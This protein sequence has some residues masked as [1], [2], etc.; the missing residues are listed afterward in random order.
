MKEEE[1]NKDILHALDQ[2]INPSVMG[3]SDVNRILNNPEEKEL[4]RDIHLL[5][6]ALLRSS[7]LHRPDVEAEWA[8]FN[9]RPTV[10][11]KDVEVKHTS[12][13]FF[14]IGAGMGI[15][16]SLI[17]VVTLIL[18]TW[19]SNETY[20]FRSSNESQHTMLFT[21]A[22]NYDLSGK[23]IADIT[24]GLPSDIDMQNNILSYNNAEG[25]ADM[26][27]DNVEVH[28]LQTP[29]GQDFKVQLS[30]GTLVWLNAESRLEYP[31]RFTGNTRMVYLSGEAYFEVA[32]DE[33]HPFLIQTKTL[34]T[35]VL[36]TEFNVSS[37]SSTNSHVTLV[38]GS[39]EVSRSDGS[40]MVRLEPGQ[41]AL[42]NNSGTFTVQTVDTD[43]YYFW[44][45]GYFYFDNVPL[46]DIMQNIGRW[47]NVNVV[48]N[49]TEHLNDRMHIFC[50]RRDGLEKVIQVISGTRRV[51][52]KVDGN[53]LYID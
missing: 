39:V 46:V 49:A 11:G 36:G 45:E 33:E 37:Y 50:S 10:R 21:S 47:Y 2:M 34:R 53:T 40:N 12:R 35:R 27:A 28:V 32:H 15:A 51:E 42:L 41:D 6:D 17:L 18:T 5:R 20:V 26:K 23:D 48:F 1:L 31:A 4:S 52:V 44:K 25:D 7:D 22:G 16:A 24:A 38:N 8:K 30:D 19:P 3:E 14:F 43:N 29:I 13:R 9:Q